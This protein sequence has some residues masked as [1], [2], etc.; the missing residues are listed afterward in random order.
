[1][2]YCRHGHAYTPDNTYWSNG[3]RQCRQCRQAARRRYDDETTHQE[4]A[5]DPNSAIAAASAE[6]RDRVLA[7]IAKYHPGARI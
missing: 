7:Y 2:N 1:M 6:L 5:V 4:I 3:L